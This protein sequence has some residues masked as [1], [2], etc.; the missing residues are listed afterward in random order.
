MRFL[1]PAAFLLLVSFACETPAAPSAS[2]SLMKNS[3]AVETSDSLNWADYDIRIEPEEKTYEQIRADIQ[4]QKTQLREAYRRKAV[5]L[6]SVGRVFEEMLVNQIIPYWYGTPWSFGGHTV[7]PREGQ[8]ACGYFISTTLLHAGVQLNRYRLAQQAPED[9][10]KALAMGDSVSV[11]QG[12]W[13][14]DVL[15][16]LQNSLKDGLYF[17]G[18]S[19]SHVGF[20]LK[21]RG[22]FFLLHSNYVYPAELR[23][24]PAGERSVLNSF[25]TFYLVPISNNP[26]LLEAWL[27]GK[28]VSVL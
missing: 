1:L 27:F 3:A 10:A 12:G 6:D 5:S 14:S 8:I 28:E 4:K 22:K 18:L 23:I 26:K 24:E 15:P 11:F 21:R 2:N 9:E 13:V 7:T 17:I 20:L 19:S 16:I 25:S